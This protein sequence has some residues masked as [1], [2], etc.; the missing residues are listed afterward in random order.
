MW[1]EGI[2]KHDFDSYAWTK[3]A[4]VAERLWSP[5][6]V[7]DLDAAQPRLISHVCRMNMRGIQA[8]PIYPS[9]CPSDI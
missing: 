6:D 8:E 2:N 4:A 9:F 7:N 3:A 5:E 1:A